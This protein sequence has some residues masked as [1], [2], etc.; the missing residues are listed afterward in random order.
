MLQIAD[1]FTKGVNGFRLYS[2]DLSI[3]N[4]A[5]DQKG[6]V[7]I[8]DAENVLVVDLEQIRQR[9]YTSLP[10]YILRFLL[11]MNFSYLFRQTI[12]F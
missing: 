10:H 1:K 9:K 2:S 7:K 12:K 8:I 5:V 6:N 11:Q 4:I 3:Y